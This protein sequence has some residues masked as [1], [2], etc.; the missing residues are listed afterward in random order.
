MSRPGKWWKW[1]SWPVFRALLIVLVIGQCVAGFFLQGESQSGSFFGSGAA[2]LALLLG[3][4]R[5]RLR[6]LARDRKMDRVFS[7]R[8][9]SVLNIARN[10]GRSTLTIGLVAAASFLIAAVSAFRL[11]TSEG[12]TG[13]FELTATS[14]LPIHYD[15]NTADGRRELGFSDS[16]S[17]E[18]ADW[19]FYSLR[20]AAGEN[21][22]CLNLYQPT[23]PTVLGVP[24]SLVERGGFA[25]AETEKQFA[26][27]PWA[28]L[29]AKLRDA[30]PVVLDA[31]TAAYSL[32]IGG[33]GSHFSI[34]DGAGREVTL[35]V[36]GL[37]EN[38]VL[39]GNLLVSEANFVKLFPEVGG[40]R[41]FLAEQVGDSKAPVWRCQSRSHGNSGV[42][43]G[44]RRV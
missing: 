5:F 2:A 8:R 28:A 33:V 3:E 42:D 15:L 10:P 26:D 25:W 36:V 24:Q 16:A 11:G 17:K 20:V 43:I 38:S 6:H 18:L 23:Q 31:S 21:A 32:H 14:D 12:G 40:Y 29:D 35:E 30:V 34:R 44:R 7:L 9:L 22:S 4:V 19:R 27:K 37:L 13:G 1:F 39:Q 41:Y